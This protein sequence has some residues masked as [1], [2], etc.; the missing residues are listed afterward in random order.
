MHGLTRAAV[1]MAA[2]VSCGISVTE[3]ARASEKMTPFYLGQHIF[4][5]P[6]YAAVTNEMFS[7]VRIWANEG[8]TWA[9]IE[10]VPGKFD[11]SK[12][13]LHVSQAKSKGFDIIHTLGQTPAWASARPDEK[14]NTGLGAAAEPADMKDWAHY[15]HEVAQHYKGVISGYEIMNEPRIPE[16][17]KLWSP[18]FFSGSS[19]ALATM[20]RIAAE[21]IKKVDPSARVICPSMDGGEQGLKRL[22]YFLSTGAGKYCD[23]IGAHFYLKTITISELRKLITGTKALMA[24]HG[25]QNLPLWDTEAGVLIAE[26]GN[27]LKAKESSGAL[28]KVFNGLDASRFAAQ[29][30]VVS[31]ML[32]VE[33]TYWFAHDSS[34]MGSTI[35]EKSLNQLNSFGKALGLINSW[36]SGRTLEDC[37]NIPT[38]LN[39]RIISRGSW[40]GNVYWGEGKSPGT[41]KSLGFKSIH[42]LNLESLSLE[43][44]DVA[45]LFPRNPDDV[46]FLSR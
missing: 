15:V 16:A 38:G 39:C 13:D 18:G 28:S 41:W 45:S 19:S 5:L 2:I 12:F 6:S 40:V 4:Y 24:K 29:F 27:N 9:Q 14:G 44:A 17:F 10:S 30:L 32:G 23:V 26:A 46:I 22:D 31:Q 34:S 36:L 20:T 33:R 8:T 21:E 7:G 43:A 35:P 11:F 37:E 1:F 3:P 42:F 25:L